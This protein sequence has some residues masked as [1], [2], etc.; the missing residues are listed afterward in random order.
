M[1]LSPII[2]TYSFEQHRTSG[3]IHKLKDC[4][5]PLQA[6][7]KGQREISCN[8]DLA[9]H[10]CSLTLSALNTGSTDVPGSAD[11]CTTEKKSI[12]K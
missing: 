11:S 10:K 5:V 9:A 8:V 2:H 1:L 7:S 6:L 4:F 3:R 12:N